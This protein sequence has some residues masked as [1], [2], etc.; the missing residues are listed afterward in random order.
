M[1]FALLLPNA[2]H[3]A[4]PRR[5]V[6]LA[7]RAEDS[8]WDGVFLWDH[9][10][11]DRRL[12]LPLADTWTAVTAILASTRWIRSGPLVA[13][14]AARHP[15]KIA[16]ET[17]TLD[18][19][20]G[21]RVILGAG[22]G[23]SDATDFA[24]FGD[25][26]GLSERAARLDEALSLIDRL[27]SG[28]EISHAGERFQLDRVTFLPVPRQRPRIPVWVAATWPNRSRGPLDRAIRWDGM[29]PMVR[30]AAG[31]LRG[32][33]EKELTGI[34]AAVGQP[35]PDW[36]LAVPGTAPPADPAWARDQAD[37]YH[38]AGAAWWLESFDPWSRNPQDA[39][40]WAAQGPPR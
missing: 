13:P 35:A 39:R 27:W 16:R 22:L 21:G 31:G 28:Q 8:G 36:T 15:W 14:L 25:D 33:T 29:V 9:L 30:D 5:L 38:S 17:V 24:A 37:R 40:A 1:R 7:R 4:D 32:P 20:S 34:L 26:S 12:K 19:L 18:H 3:Y 2:G 11:L 10:M 23:A 6:D